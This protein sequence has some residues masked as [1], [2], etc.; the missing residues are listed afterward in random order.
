[1]K[2]IF[3]TGGHYTPAKAVIDLLLDKNEFEI[4]YLG[5]KSAMEDDKA[6]A[7]E[8]IELSSKPKITYLE[9]TTGRLQ[10]NFFVNF[11]QSVRAFLKI[12]TGFFQSLYYLVKYRP[13]LV[14]SFGGYLAI[15]VVIN[16]WFFGIP[17][18][19]HEQTL[20]PGL[21][22]RLIARFSKKVLTGN[23][24][25]REI[26]NLKPVRQSNTIFITGGNQGAHVI[27][28]A[29]EEIIDKLLKKYRVIHQTG[30]SKFEDYERLKREG[31]FKFL[32]AQEMA[33]ALNAAALVISRSGAN[34]TTE[35]A[36][37][38]K[39]AI[40]IP[41]PWSSGGEQMANAKVLESAGTA[42]ILEQKD[43]NGQNL[44]RLIG[45]MMENLKQYNANAVKARKLV[46]LDATE[47]I[48]EE[49]S[50]NA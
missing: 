28:V 44:L 4:F 30:D 11:N 32:D 8:F 45:S 25:R 41:I 26:L 7:L 2:K 23:P 20:A 50:K 24:L 22:N 3:I 27:N 13:N 9:L 35:L 16:A 49:I 12:F 5:R 47:K 37:L 10:R 33:D 19:T 29:I 1:M 39:P 38:G 14:M 36:Y 18:L 15:P 43:L 48:V 42:E 46:E 31:V 34:I 6:L 40:L 21:A 17:V